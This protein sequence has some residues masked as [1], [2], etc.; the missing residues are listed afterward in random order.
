MANEKIHE[1]L[2]TRTAGTLLGT[3]FFDLDATDDLGATWFSHK[4]TVDNLVT[5][6]GT[7]GV[8]LYNANGILQSERTILSPNLGITLD[9]GNFTIEMNDEVTDHGFLLN[10]S[11]SLEWGR[12]G[13]DQ[14]TASGMLEL[15][16]IGGVWF[17]ANDGE[18][19]L[20]GQDDSDA[21]SIF[22]GKNSSL[23]NI[24][25]F[26]NNGEFVIGVPTISTDLFHSSRVK[27]VFNMAQSNSYI[28]LSNAP[29]DGTTNN[30]TADNQNIGFSTRNSSGDVVR[31]VTFATVR[32][33]NVTAGSEYGVLTIGDAIQTE[34]STGTSARTVI[35]TRNRNTSGAAGAVLEVENRD[36]S[37]TATAFQVACFDQGTQLAIGVR[38]GSAGTS[39]DTWNWRLKNN[40][41]FEHNYG[42]LET[43]DFIM[44]SLND[45]SVFHM[46]SGTNNVGF[47]TATP[48]TSSIVEFTSTT[49]GIRQTP[50]T[51]A[52]AAAITPV[53]GLIVMVSDT[54]A[55]FT[56]IGFWGYQNG[57]WTKM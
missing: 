42:Q 26:R 17:D 18:V 19:A 47:G 2:L 27:G 31:V 32:N 29:A 22:N 24:F 39:D 21:T 28:E 12:F 8:N 57:S 37:A 36:T 14:G 11:G 45:V 9:A 55:T 51:S 40:H 50:M 34:N 23:D 43:G 20:F 15:G 41:E 35:S 4:L 54:D 16:N 52:Q 46:N 38:S 13:I 5:Y 1:Y 44:R 10:N 7:N 53:E 49:M 56:S 6:I 25:D 30:T 48:S 3:E 33:R